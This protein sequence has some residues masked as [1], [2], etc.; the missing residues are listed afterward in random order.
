VL[1]GS[2]GLGFV[3]SARDLA[4]GVFANL[5]RRFQSLDRKVGAGS[6]RMSGAFREMGLGLG[7]MAG[8][9]VLVGG[10]FALADKAGQ[11]EQAIAAVAAVSGATRAELSQL[12]DAAIEAG[13]ATQFSPTEATVGLK[14][15]AQAGFSAQESIKL[16]IPVLDLA[17]GSLGELTPAQAAGLAS[18]ALKA[19]GISAED[20]SIAVDRMLQAVNVFAL[21]ASELPMA[22]GN[23][24]R[25]AQ[26]LKQSMSET[27]ITLGLVKNIIPGVE[28]ASTGVAVAMERLAEPKVQEHLKSI[29]VTVVDSIGHFRNFLDVLGDLAPELEKMTDAKRAA[30]L[31]DTFG[32]HA[33]GSVQAVLTQVTTGIKTN[34][35]ETLKGGAAI[36]YLRKQFEQAGGTAASFRDKMLDTFAG[37]RQLLRGSLETLAIVLGEPFAQVFK[38]I[39][40]A[41]ID[42]LNGFLKFVRGMPAGLKRGIATFIVA[43]GA[44]ITLIGAALSAKAA[45][46]MFGLALKAAGVTL[47]GL[48]LTLAPVVAV[49]GLL[50]LLVWGFALAFRKNFGSIADFAHRAWTVVSMF[51][52]G[53]KQLFED[54]GFSGALRTELN[55]AENAGLKDFLINVYLWANRLKNL[56]A[57]IAKGFSAG[58]EAA[59]PS[60][61][62][63]L[64]AL[65]ALGVELGFLGD[66]DDA[67]TAGAKF[68]AF[69]AAG[70]KIGLVLGKVFELLVKGLTV[71][72]DFSRGL[73]ASWVAIRPAAM[74]LFGALA[75]L[76]G[77]LGDIVRLVAG[78]SAATRDGASV[79]SAF[80]TVVGW[81]IAAVIA[82]IGFLAAR[83][84]AAMAWVNA[85]IASMMAMF[86]GIADVITGVVYVI[87]GIVTGSWKDV[88]TG[89]KLIAFGVISAIISAVLE[90]VGAIG[91]A[92]D[93]MAGFVG[94]STNIQKSIRDFKDGVNSSLA[95][96]LA[97][98]NVTFNGAA[99]AVPTGPAVAHGPPTAAGVYP[100]PAVA[101]AGA[102]AAPA[103]P[104]PVYGPPAAPKPVVIQLQLDGQTIATAV[105][106]AAADDAARAF[107][108]LPKY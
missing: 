23:A 42:A 63:F 1:N 80:G 48:L 51:F 49:V 3:F 66:R 22:L 24:S 74:L 34:T 32:A 7:I 56:F 40:A 101:A 21:N 17:G 50:G 54:G 18:Q 57:G 78:S 28:R 55:R 31:I 13:I 8:G 64:V 14:E 70:Q 89:M 92:V 67:G 26:A 76:A 75:R 105:H 108:T 88:W 91:G 61:N 85:R 47:G 99:A 60:I 93:S 9:A 94:K 39:L 44:L 6:D 10:A 73:A 96:T 16:L 5:E 62:A 30:F 53:V 27:L 81:V 45:I 29:G 43:A 72:V 104:A 15:L 106:K 86:S 98:D 20:A 103:A 100:M 65:R 79:W 84:G 71:L 19:F 90:F 95:K 38:P 97:V 11:F 25:G 77:Q 36:G 46:V 4:S 102:A 69:G 83:I 87:G 33:L 82:S 35:G 58:V 41:V 12:H 107:S 59:K 52:E 2:M 37:Q 68:E